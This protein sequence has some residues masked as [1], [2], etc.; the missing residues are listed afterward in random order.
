MESDTFK[1]AAT[2]LRRLA[3]SDI[4][5]AR[6]MFTSFTDEF[7]TEELRRL[8]RLLPP[9]RSPEPSFPAP[10]PL[11][12]LGPDTQTGDINIE[13]IAGRDL[14][15]NITVIGKV[16]Y[17]HDPSS[18]EQRRLVMYLKDLIG[19]VSRL[20]LRGLDSRLDDGGDGMDLSRVYT[21]L[22]AVNRAPAVESG[23][24]ALLSHYFL[25]HNPKNPLKQ[26]FHPDFAMPDQAVVGIRY[27]VNPFLGDGRK[28]AD[29]RITAR[30][31]IC[32]AIQW[33]PTEHP[34]NPDPESI[35]TLFRERLLTEEV[36]TH[37]RMLLL[38]D[39]GSGKSTF[40]RHLALSFA[41]NGL[42]QS[43]SLPGW[44]EMPKLLPMLIALRRLDMEL[45]RDQAAGADSSVDQVIIRL[46]AGEIQGDVTSSIELVRQ[47]LQRNVLLM[48][49]DGLDEVPLEPIHGRSVGRMATLRAVQ[50]FLQT[51]S[52]NR[53]IISCRT[54]AYDE[55]LQ[56]SIRWETVYVGRFTLGQIR[57]FARAWYAELVH[58]NQL[59][60]IQVTQL[61]QM[62]VD[63]IVTSPR[64][65]ALA[66][67]PLLL[68]MMA[69]ILYHD[70]SLPRDRP[71]LYER[72][73]DLLLGQ[74]DKVKEGQSLAEA[75]GRPEWGSE[76][77]RPLIDQ[78]SYQ[79]HAGAASQD[80]RGRIDRRDLYDGLIT[81]FQNADLRDPWSAAGRCL[82]YFEQ[83]SGLIVPD[84]NDTYVFAHLTLQEHCAGRHMLLSQEAR[85]LVQ[86]HRNDDRWREPIMLGLGAIQRIN[87]ALIENILYD[88]IDDEE[89]G[90]Q[91]TA[92]QLL[93]D[94]ILAAEIGKDRDWS[95]LRTQRVNVSRIQR[96]LKAGF[97]AL[98][99]D[100]AQPLPLSERVRLATALGE[101][102]DPRLPVSRDEWRYE[103]E[104][105]SKGEESGYFCRIPPGNYTVGVDFPQSDLHYGPRHQITID[106][107]V[108]IGRFL[109]T[110]LQWQRFVDSME[111]PSGLRPDRQGPN[112]PLV[113]IHSE[114]VQAFC[115]WLSADVGCTIR[116]PTEYEWEAAA[117]GADGRRYPWGNSWN[118]ALAA[119]Q[120]DSAER[121]E[122]LVPV[123]VY[124]TGAS[125]IGC[126]DMAGLA[127]EW[128]CSIWKS[129]A[130]DPVP[131]ED[132]E[133]YTIRGGGY[134]SRPERTCCYVRDC[135]HPIHRL[136][137]LGFRVV[138]A[139]P[140]V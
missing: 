79:T 80:G 114:F 82:T 135:F 134:R 34:P 48:L 104:R 78:L 20:S 107:P 129:Y 113:G 109:I 119:T 9:L 112:F 98:L 47:A 28:R 81:Y 31:L 106:A 133:N 127:W 12:Q 2:V 85:E 11:M 39:P 49:F 14:F 97:V 70:N 57:H 51:R 45:A 75:I 5:A 38:G 21:V 140:V 59:D 110:E 30:T 22:A 1:F 7:S 124:P 23:T 58:A 117:R 95:Y 13:D 6:R 65:R 118:S 125:P 68:T 61:G 101:L 93:Q 99:S 121:N 102:G 56:K 64:L 86:R 33:P 25:E 88:L 84:E 126:L 40:L 120:A 63:V 3:A 44:E 62:L 50:R 53:A 90:R 71:L 55:A 8:E 76:R 16:I 103:I 131:F 10:Q 96:D 111:D 17:G 138:L 69:L 52:E 36:Y 37:K 41:L 32:E 18:D 67:N 72:L 24:R 139:E 27:D 115:E 29:R 89:T 19:R 92:Y 83:R 137:V 130:D 123:G 105:A 100:R 136:P 42:G 74:W 46:F 15:K 43:I 26:E 60:R 66:E 116:L 4:D 77:L 73:L 35:I 87:P 128:T 94:L 91:K 54:R 108:W 132:P 122:L